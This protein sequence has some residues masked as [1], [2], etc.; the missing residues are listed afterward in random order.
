MPIP[1]FACPSCNA[2]LVAR[3]GQTRAGQETDGLV[4]DACGRRL[5]E[6]EAECARQADALSAGLFE[7]LDE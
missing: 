4:C 5:T 3:R 7:E 2:I 1:R 6:A